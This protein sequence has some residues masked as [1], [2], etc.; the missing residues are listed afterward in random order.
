MREMNRSIFWAL[1]LDTS[2]AVSA[3]IGMHMLNPQSDRFNE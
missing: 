3:E 2:K 1:T